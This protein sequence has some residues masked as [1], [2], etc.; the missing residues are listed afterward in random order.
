MKRKLNSLLKIL[1]AMLLLTSMA[2]T[3]LLGTTSAEYFKSFN[4][5]LDLEMNPDLELEYFLRDYTGVNVNSSGYRTTRGIYETAKAFS[6]EIVIG[7]SS[8]RIMDVS[9]ET[10]IKYNS[11]NV[12]C[13]QMVVYQIKLPVDETGYYNLN[14]TSYFVHGTV[15]SNDAPPEFPTTRQDDEAILQDYPTINYN[16]AVGCEI[17]TATDTDFQFGSAKVLDMENRVHASD[18]E[19]KYANE[20]VLYADSGVD[21]VYQWKTLCPSRSEDVA[22]SFKVTQADVDRGYVIWAWDMSGLLGECRYRFEC[23]SLSFE[24]TMELDGTTKTRNGSTDPYFMFPQTSY[25]NNQVALYTEDKGSNVPGMTQ[26]SNGRGT[27]V[28]AATDNS[29][30]MQAET[31]WWGV[32]SDGKGNSGYD[33]PISIFV[34]LKNIKP[35][36]TYKV[37]FDFSIARQ[38]EKGVSKDVIIKDPANQPS[39]LTGSQKDANG[40][41]AT[42]AVNWYDYADFD[43]ILSNAKTD[44]NFLSYISTTNTGN[45]GLR[46]Y[47]DHEPLLGDVKYNHKAYE[48]EPLVNYNSLTKLPA[49]VSDAALPNFT[50]VKS[51]NDTYCVTLRQAGDHTNT[52]SRNWFNAVQHTE[53]NGQYAINWITMYNTTFS[54]N[55]NKDATG[56]SVNADTGC[57]DSLYWTWVIDAFRTTAYHRIKI[58]NV[59]IEEVV[60]YA[61]KMDTNGVKIGG[62]QVSPSANSTSY[63]AYNGYDLDSNVFYSLRGLNGTGQ[64]YLARGYS[65]DGSGSM[66]VD[67]NYKLLPRGNIYAPVLDASKMPAGGTSGNG[68]ADAYKIELS[69]WVVCEGGVSKY[70]Y[71]ADGGKTWHDMKFTGTNIPAD[72]ERTDNDYTK[73]TGIFEEAMGQIEPVISATTHNYSHLNDYNFVNFGADTGDDRN[74]NFADWSLVADL[75]EYAA[76]NYLDII[77][78]AV[79]VADSNMRCEFLRIINYN[80]PNSYVSNIEGI[81]SD[82]DSKQG[83]DIKDISVLSSAGSDI[84]VGKFAYYMSCSAGSDPYNNGVYYRKHYPI[85]A[86]GVYSHF[87]YQSQ[88][89]DYSNVHAVSSDIPIK[90]QLTVTGGTVALQGVHSYYYSVDGGIT[91]KPITKGAANLGYNA[92]GGVDQN[93]NGTKYQKL[94]FNI[95]YA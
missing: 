4:K 18:T 20:T 40:D 89:I 80:T 65:Y 13:G 76:E 52:T 94:F 87:M 19:T 77:F 85:A 69:G 25:A 90:T 62:V 60:Q 64:N 31:L 82:I 75:S 37:T 61:S 14:F 1:V 29:L 27:F 67:T 95:F 2:I 58:E 10:Y 68:H 55:I 39:D 70:V 45:D 74:G 8:A 22:L 6:Q 50:T 84:A 86:R 78:A 46:R 66:E 63:T 11:A 91:W 16:Y 59:R 38:G 30:T 32:D 73:S 81:Y 88:P 28:T 21:T 5:K 57:Y 15:G 36:V 17:L 34:P 56:K 7:Q 26:Y 9:S 33:N 93:N 71:S 42:V 54:F 83:N 3:T 41:P 49:E 43:R 72:K 48:N 92:V 47:S 53:Y 79:P 51:V 35:G 23:T 24:K 12:Y 44:K